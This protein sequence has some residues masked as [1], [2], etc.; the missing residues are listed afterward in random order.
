MVNFKME[1]VRTQ[2]DTCPL[3][4]H[5]NIN[6]R[7]EMAGTNLTNQQRCYYLFWIISP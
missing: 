6:L 7:Y 3:I 1:V 2:K 4:T 5:Y